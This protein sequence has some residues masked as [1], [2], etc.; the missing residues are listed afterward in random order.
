MT[1]L[2][3]PLMSALMRETDPTPR[4]V[5]VE[6]TGVFVVD[7]GDVHEALERREYIVCICRD[8]SHDAD[9][10]NWCG[11]YKVRSDADDAAQYGGHV[12]PVFAYVVV[13]VAA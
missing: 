11:T 2:D 10:D 9:S 13:G 3:A 12:V 8:A 7:H 4:T 6:A 5:E 1:A